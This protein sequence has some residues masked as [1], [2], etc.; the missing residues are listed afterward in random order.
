MAMV[1]FIFNVLIWLVPNVARKWISKRWE[2]HTTHHVEGSAFDM[3]RAAVNLMVAA[4]VISFATSKKLPLSTTYVT[5]IVAMGTSLVDRA[6]DRDCAPNRITGVMTVVGG[7]FVTAIMA[8]LMSGAI[9][10]MLH[11]M[12]IYG[13][14]AMVAL[15]CA[16]MYKLFRLHNKRTIEASLMLRN[17]S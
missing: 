15:C 12:Q 3:L 10:A 17:S 4:A 5:F 9:V 13:L 7:W 14:L 2:R 16:I 11:L 8:F 1:V 6:W